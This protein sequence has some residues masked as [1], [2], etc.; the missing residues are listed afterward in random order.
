MRAYSGPARKF[1]AMTIG[2][3]K[4]SVAPSGRPDVTAIVCGESWLLLAFSSVMTNEHLRLSSS[5]NEDHIIV[6]Y[7]A[8]IVSI[9]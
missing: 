3:F 1:E 5:V 8:T 2:V 4:G 9:S 7:P 6:R